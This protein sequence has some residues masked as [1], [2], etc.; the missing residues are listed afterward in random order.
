MLHLPA[1]YAQAHPAEDF[2]ETFAVWLTPRSQ[3]R[4]RYR[5]WPALQKLEYIDEL[6]TALKG[7][8]DDGY[9]EAAK[10]GLVGGEVKKAG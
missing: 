8:L 9:A 4:R 5:G 3:W 6:M 10:K 1:W 2:A 7:A